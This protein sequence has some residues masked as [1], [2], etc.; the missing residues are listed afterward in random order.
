MKRRLA[1]AA[2]GALFTAA[3]LLAQGPPAAPATPA[4]PAPAVKPPGA[5]PET[6]QVPVDRP[7]RITFELKVPRE[8]GG[9]TLA[10]SAQRIETAGEDQAELTGDIEIKY[11]DLTFRADHAVLHRDTMTVEAEGDVVLDQSSR[12][13]A[14]QRADFD[15]DTETGTFFQA[16]AYAEPDQ[17]FTGAVLRKTG[18]NSFE[19]EKGIVTSCTGDPTPDWSFR[20]RH[21]R[22]DIGGYAHMRGTTMRVKKL[23]VL[24][25]P[26]MIWPAR[27]ERTSGLLVPNIG[28]TANKGAYLGLAYYQVMGPSADLTLQLDGYANTYAGAGTE[29]RYAPREGTKGDLSY[30]MLANRDTQQR[31]WRAVWDHTA[32]KLPGGF[33]GV[34]SVNEYSDYNFFRQFQRLE[35]ENTRSF[36]Y[37][38]AFLS[39]DWGA[40]SLSMQIDQRE[41][42]LGSGG[43][44]TQSKL[45][46]VNFQLRKLKLGGVPLYLSMNSTASYLQSKTDKL[47][48]VSYGRLDLAPELTLPVRVAPWLNLTLNGGG[49]A[50]WWGDSRSTQRVD[51]LTGVRE[52][53]CDSGVV[54]NDQLYCGETLTRIYPDAGFGVVGPSFSKIFD[55]PGG[56]F[57]KFKHIIEPRFTYSYVGNFDDQAKVPRFDQI[58]AF[59][60]AQL[61]TVSLIN[62]VL[63]KPTDETQGGAFEMLSFTLTQS[64]SLDDTQ[65]LQKSSDGSRS[66]TAG[67]ISAL[68]R[69]SSSKNFDLQAKADW[70]TL[71]ANLD[72]TSLSARAQ[73][74]RASMNLT[75]YTNYNV[76]S[77]KS[78]TDQVRFGFSLDMIKDRLTLS[79][80]VNYDLLNAEIQQ[81]NYAINYKSQCWGV[82]L[83][84]RE[85]ITSTYTTRDYRFLLTLKN[86]GTFLDLHG[87][88]RAEKF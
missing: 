78:V 28:Y 22:V 21:A 27:T 79:G 25:L 7:D 86:V 43:T 67:P 50:T 37:S 73:G 4:T 71:F 83:E 80:Q 26:Y 68:L 13:I 24:Y 74:D 31:E 69:V 9:G 15:L 34:I 60:A 45:P 30:Y 6:P 32:S 42:F 88:N 44:S 41:T 52:T 57:S 81:Q 18:E 47:F 20:V 75:W 49:R 77:G 70:S 40:Q 59:G 82:R 11:R 64:F 19:I 35:D 85:Q 61:G 46:E 54:G 39:G 65:P 16:T 51:P 2:A 17:Y 48:D 66:S 63:A 38:N 10:G 76:E 8:R 3:T 5:A 29:V 23:P 53:I 56:R 72:S 58:D 36:L 1:C 33:R 84:G 87:G 12:R 14:A 55:S 62:R